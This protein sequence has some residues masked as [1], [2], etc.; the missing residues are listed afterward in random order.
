MYL[1][2]IGR[3]PAGTTTIYSSSSK[4]NHEGY[5]G[6]GHTR[7]IPGVF[8]MRQVL[9]EVGAATE[10]TLDLLIG[11]IINE[12]NKRLLGVPLAFD[13]KS[14]TDQ[15]SN[16][17]Q[18]KPSLEL[19][20]AEWLSASEE[21]FFCLDVTGYGHLRFDELHFLLACLLLGINR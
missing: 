7:V 18:L 3:S 16:S 9:I 15:A 10:E 4:L 14:V 2:W 20:N 6:A 11:M 1:V 19:V 5:R 12:V 17:M 8:V 21:L 13:P